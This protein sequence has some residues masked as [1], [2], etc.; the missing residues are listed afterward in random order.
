MSK[1]AWRATSRVD[2]CRCRE[3]LLHRTDRWIVE[4]CLGPLGLGALI[5]K[6]ERH[7]VHVADVDDEEATELGPLLREAARVVTD[8][9]DPDQVYVSLW[10][11]AGGVPVHIHHVVQP[12]TRAMVEEFGRGPEPAECD[13]RRRSCVRS[14]RPSGLRRRGSCTLRS[15]VD[16]SRYGA[17]AVRKRRRSRTGN[18]ASCDRARPLGGCP[19]A[20]PGGCFVRGGWTLE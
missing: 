17:P 12:V 8:L 15:I 13:V 19:C 20:V 2:D 1:G 9:I 11:H 10:S 14:R 6:P 16:C 5:V 7:V 3:G 18:L 4:M